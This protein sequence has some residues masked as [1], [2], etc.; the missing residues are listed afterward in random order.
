MQCTPKGPLRAVVPSRSRAS[1]P[2]AR[3]RRS[4]ARGGIPATRGRIQADL[5]AR[6]Q[7]AGCHRAPR[8]RGCRRGQARRR[9]RGSGAGVAVSRQ[10][11]PGRRAR[12]T[13]AVTASRADAML[14]VRLL[15]VDTQMTV[16]PTPMGP[17]P[18]FG[19]YGFYSGLVR[20]SAGHA[21]ADRGGRDD[22]VRRAEPAHR[23]E[24]DLRDAESDQRAEGRA[25]IRRRD[26]RLAAQGRL[27]AGRQ[28][29]AL[30]VRAPS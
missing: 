12:S 15:G 17:G 16:W 26:P 23:L 9:R 30:R 8:A 25:G 20:L 6:A 19:W 29:G 28:V 13:A 14:M 3:R 18:R 27:A 11:R 7:H 5:R 10:R 24:R 1:S 4:R 2:A 21:D 22:A